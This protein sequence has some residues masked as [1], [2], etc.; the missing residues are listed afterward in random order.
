MIN[1]ASKCWATQR[2]SVKYV[3]KHVFQEEEEG[4]S[5]TPLSGIVTFVTSMDC[6]AG[7]DGGLCAHVF[8]VL[9]SIDFF[10]STIDSTKAPAGP[11]SITSIPQ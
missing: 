8:A 6:V 9:H 1:V 2:K 11:E 7:A 3:Q 4:E 5:G 10:C